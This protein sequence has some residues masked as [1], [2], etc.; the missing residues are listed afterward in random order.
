MAFILKICSGTWATDSRDRREL[1]VYR[2]LGAQVAVLAKGDTEDK[3][4]EELVD[5]FTVY[6]YTTRPLGERA[7]N[8]INRF[9]AL[10]TWASFARK[11]RPDVISGHD[12]MPSLLI[13]RMACMFNSKKP[14]LIYDSHEFELGRNVSRGKASAFFVRVLEK[15]LMKKC[16]FSIMVNDSIADE[17]QRIH[18]LND[19]PVVIR[20]TP[21]KWNIDEGECKRVREELLAQYG[22][23]TGDPFIVMYHGSLTTGR[24]IETVIKLTAENRNIYSVIL[25]Y[26]EDSYTSSLHKMAEEL[27]VTGRLIFHDKVGHE[28]LWKYVGAVDMSLMMIDA[29]AKS[30]YYALPNK[31]FESIHSLTPIVASDFP[32]MKRLID[33]YGIGLTCSPDDMDAINGCVEKMRTDREFYNRCKTNMTEARN[34][35]CWENE[36]RILEEAYRRYINL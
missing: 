35:L 34:D 12:L 16:A 24:G 25:G 28:I 3:G 29:I 19:R 2:D 22:E 15:S 10:F 9:V 14:K 18:K 32:E 17:V 13:A 6:R 11:L 8:F 27:G 23:K 5:G 33:R 21:S 31:F 1:S 30:Y 4:R 36:R 26:G 7:P 20:S